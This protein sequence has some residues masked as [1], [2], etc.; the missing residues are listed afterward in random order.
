MS[1]FVLPPEVNS[2]LML[3]G[4]GTGPLLAAAAAWE[5]LSAELES[6]A[7]S[8]TSTASGLVGG[9]WQGASAAA[10]AA[11][12]MPYAGWLSAAATSAQ[13][14]AGQAR[15]AVGA[16]ESALAA[17]VHPLV[18]A[19]N[20]SDFVSLAVS[21]LIGQNTAAIA[22]TESDYELM[23]AQD[24][25]AMAGYHL[26]AS[27]AISGLQGFLRPLASL[28]GGGGTV[29]ESAVDSAAGAAAGVIRELG[30]SNPGSPDLGQADIG[31]SLL[32]AGNVGT[33]N[34]DRLNFGLG[35][36]GITGNLFSGPTRLSPMIDAGFG[37]AAWSSQQAT[38]AGGLLDLF[39][40]S[41]PNL[42]NL[43][44]GRSGITLNIF[45][46]SLPLAADLNGGF[47]PITIPSVQIFPTI[48]LNFNHTFLLGPLAVP[49]IYI[50]EFR[51]GITIPIDIGPLTISPITLFTAQTIVD[52]FITIPGFNLIP[53]GVTIPQITQI[54]TSV[55]SNTQSSTFIGPIHINTAI[56]PINFNL[57]L[58]TPNITL[59]PGGLSIPDNPLHLDVGA[60]A[61]FGDFTI[62]GFSLPQNPIPLTI[63][64]AGQIDGLSTPPIIIDGSPGNVHTPI[65]AYLHA[66]LA[67]DRGPL[68]PLPTELDINVTGFLGPFHLEPLPISPPHVSITNASIILGSFTVPE[69]TIPNIPMN[70]TGT[71][72]LAHNT[73]SALILDPLNISGQLGIGAISGPSVLVDALNMPG[74]LSITATGIGVQPLI[75]SAGPAIFNLGT[76]GPLAITN[77][78]IPGQNL[79]LLDLAGGTDPITLF[80]GGLTFPTNSVSLT[81]FAAGI[82]PF[83]VFPN[84][85][86]V[87]R[88]PFSIHTTP[89]TSGPTT[90]GLGPIHIPAV[91]VFNPI[92][93]DGAGGVNL[94]LSLPSVP[95]PAI[96]LGLHGDTNYGFITND[97]ISISPF[98]AVGSLFVDQFNIQAHIPSFGLSLG[99]NWGPGATFAGTIASFT[100]GTTAGPM[101]IPLNFGTGPI[102]IGPLAIGGNVPLSFPLDVFAGSTVPGMT[103]SQQIPVNFAFDT[104]G[105]NFPDTTIPAIPIGGRTVLTVQSGLLSTA[106]DNVVNT[107]R[108]AVALLERPLLNAGLG[109]AGI[110]NLGSGNLGDLNLGNGNIGSGNWG[111]GNIGG[112]NF[113][114]G[115][116]AL[117]ALAGHNIGFGNA[118]AGNIGFGNSGSG[119]IGFG[120]TG[121]G[122]MGIGLIGD[123]RNGFGGWNSGSGNLGLF[124]SGDH[125]VGLFNSG[126]NNTGVGNSGI[127]DTGVFN[128]GPFDIGIGNAGD[129]NLGIFNAGSSNTGAFNPGSFD[130]GLFNRG[131]GD[132]GLA[133][134][135][136]F[137]NG[138]FISG[139]HST[140]ALLTGDNQGPS[141]AGVGINV[142]DINSN[143]GPVHIDPIHFA[144]LPIDVHQ[145]INLGPFTIPQIDVPAIPLDTHQGLTLPAITLFGGT[146][147]PAQTI[148]IPLGSDFSAGS[149]FTLP[150]LK[151][152]LSNS[153]PFNGDYFIGQSSHPQDANGV[154]TTGITLTSFPGSY[155]QGALSLNLPA[156]KIP[157]IATAPV[158]LGIDVTGGI[159]AFTLFPGGLS[160][161]QQPIPVNLALTGGL[162]PF[163]LFPNGYTIDP[164]N[165]HLRLDA[166]LQNPLDPTSPGR[167]VNFHLYGGLDPV[168]I[169]DLPI[170]D[171]VF[172]LGANVGHGTFTIPSI[173]IPNVP[174]HVSG[175]IG[176]GP[177]GI[178]SV[179]IPAIAGNP[180]ATLNYTS[181]SAGSK[182][183]QFVI[184]HS[185]PAPWDPLSATPTYVA[186]GTNF[187]GG[188][189]PL[190]QDAG[191]FSG[192]T[193]GPLT[194]AINATIA[195]LATPALMID[196]IPLS[197]DVPGGVDGA[198][199]FPGGLT[200]PANNLLN[201]DLSAG[202]QAFTIASR[203]VPHIPVDVN[204]LVSIHAF[205]PLDPR[206]YTPPFNLLDLSV[207]GGVGPAVL[208]SFHI[209]S[210][211]LGLN[212][213]GGIGPLTTPVIS[214]P[215]IHL[216]IEPTVDA[217]PFTLQPF[218]INLPNL[219]IGI[220][221][222]DI[223]SSVSITN[224]MVRPSGFAF[225]VYGPI[226]IGGSSSS[227]IK[228][229]NIAP[230]TVNFPGGGLP[231]LTIPVDPIHV[232]L[233]LSL[234]IPSLTFPALS[235]TGIPLGL[236]LF[237]ALPAFD[238]PAITINAIPI[239]LFGPVT[240]L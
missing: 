90:G 196:K 10:M 31:S 56:N 212:L 74:T 40:I 67:A 229:F 209:P 106:V 54:S 206:S 26:D 88:I 80:P 34:I 38:A 157:Q 163:T 45:P 184:W 168:K 231:G 57:H 210:I 127:G 13:S 235:V 108:S 1:F 156:I 132:V 144:G 221:V 97:P 46:I 118:G 183:S 81:N 172:G 102:N 175:N 100:L 173:P 49:P 240:A 5:G 59:F 142:F 146:N 179:S 226:D 83:T 138:L 205:N 130:T 134:S 111:G 69:I 147:I 236:N 151:L 84:G 189:V 181:T 51:G 129:H 17:T 21:N 14:A 48:P 120:N 24:V 117:G 177:I 112:A 187:T 128:A 76:A 33:G 152:T 211:P 162:Q 27:A 164:I 92:H 101:T 188:T 224:L 174:V 93:L 194:A 215:E 6:A 20:R 107:G 36:A 25:A 155:S 166:I 109:D 182:I 115:N 195:S 153:F 238:T 139:N 75:T 227:V 216:G 11:A 37:S 204:G 124:N 193:M 19:A 104:S 223:P 114:W 77:F 126:S 39:P 116:S 228:G 95:L 119:N 18:V 86:G 158:P 15:A 52:Q 192:S 198:T 160:I 3:S 71:V 30:V 197:F 140:G 68:L 136:S 53:G 233:P 41:F 237:G 213:S 203:T 170:P 12:A 99:I 232:E 171:I 137:D 7:F 125:N 201:L 199:F 143:F 149:S 131:D 28:P 169:P 185:G 43:I 23:W 190:P 50:P 220:N 135:G 64:I 202:T 230:F 110:Y 178:P 32:P 47:G 180:L 94:N 58:S 141:G 78:D 219:N 234:T 61:G 217:G 161:P 148:T 22:A 96:S 9:A 65:P 122:N 145:T 150:V 218:G 70:A 73:L 105:V 165:L 60:L 200:F 167:L 186:F 91:P 63:S 123:H 133:N 113:G 154:P 98:G 2:A 62:P 191:F 121:N 66:V 207:T 42:L 8:F 29:V 35:S 103:L 4:A 159:P 55:P 79:V 208:P 85:F 239:N 214:T 176:V 225:A 72:A 222:S 82:A 16:Y 89:F 44:P 87:D